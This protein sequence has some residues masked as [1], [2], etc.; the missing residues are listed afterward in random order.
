[1]I[2]P[3]VCMC[4]FFLLKAMQQTD[5]KRLDF[6][7]HPHAILTNQTCQQIQIAAAPILF[8]LCAEHFLSLQF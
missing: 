3:F 6:I 2:W 4:V 7:A 1:M 8:A 5:C